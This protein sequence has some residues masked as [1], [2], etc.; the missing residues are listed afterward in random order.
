MLFWCSIGLLL[1]GCWF[2]ARER[3]PYAFMVAQVLLLA[4]FLRGATSAWHPIREARQHGFMLN[5]AAASLLTGVHDPTQ[6]G[7]VYFAVDQLITASRYLKTNRLSVFASPTLSEFGTSL[8]NDFP[9]LYGPCTGALES[10]TPISEGNRP[11]LRLS[12]W[13]WDS[14]HQRPPSGIIVTI[15]DAIRG[16]GAVGQWRPAASDRKPAVPAGYVGFVGYVPQPAPGAM[17]NV[18]AVLDGS[19]ATACYLATR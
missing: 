19:P 13:A 9:V 15:N 2:Y 3:M 17:V 7:Q 10:V 4:I 16:V 6:L 12:G 18:Y 14:L 11:G 5:V 1:L 8:R